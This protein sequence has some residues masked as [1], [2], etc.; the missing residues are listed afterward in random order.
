VAEFPKHIVPGTIRDRIIATGIFGLPAGMRFSTIVTLG[1]G[2]ATAAHDFAHGRLFVGAVYPKKT[3]GFA[4]RNVDLRLDAG[5]PVAGTS[6]GLIAEAF[7]VFNTFEGGCLEAN[8]SSPRFGQSGCVVNLP[9]RY[10]VGL[11][12][13]F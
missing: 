7:N 10:Q 1:T 9:R 6:V 2:A 12:F 5:V 3:G 4:E 8:T 11:K 13:G